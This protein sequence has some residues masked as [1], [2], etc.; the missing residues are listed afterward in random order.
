MNTP[1]LTPDQVDHY[2]R[3]G[4]VLVP[5]LVPKAVVE[6]MVATT[7][8][9]LPPDQAYRR[10]SKDWMPTILDFANPDSEYEV[11]E[12]FVTPRV[13]AAVE[14]LFEGPA[15]CYFGMLATVN[16][17]G[18]RGLEWHQ[19]NQYQYILGHALNTF[20]ACTEITPERCNLWVSPGSHLKGVQPNIAADE[21]SHRKA[22]DP[23][24][25]ICLPTLTPG[26]AC[27]FNRNTLHRSLTN[28]TDQVRH[29]YAAQ[30]SEAKARS[31]G[32]GDFKVSNKP[33][34]RDLAARWEALKQR[35]AVGAAG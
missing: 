22:A 8:R 28:N 34:A 32:T 11:H 17:H 6:R 21:N 14:Q 16:P 3:H 30:Y 2:W 1:I 24:N 4:Y 33:M 20:V 12:A 15:R 7:S 23:G 10:E 18:G 26:D 27:I 9:P 29:A 5:G 35:L 13:I 19:D 25:G 31:A